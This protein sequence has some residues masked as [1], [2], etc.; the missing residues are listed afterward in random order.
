MLYYFPKILPRVV[1]LSDL[2]MLIMTHEQSSAALEE[3]KKKRQMLRP[4]A[5][6]QNSKVHFNSIFNL[7]AFKH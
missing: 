6:M 3:K 1:N 4:K 2:P 7:K 5:G